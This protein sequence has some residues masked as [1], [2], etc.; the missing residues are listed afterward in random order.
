[1]HSLFERWVQETPEATAVVFE[2]ESLSYAA[3]E[4]RANSIASALVERGVKA[5]D[6]VGLYVER[7]ADMLAALLGILK[8]GAA[9]VPMDPLFPADRLAYML[10]DAQVKLVLTQ[11]ALLAE[12]PAGR[13]DGKAR[14][15]RSARAWARTWR[16]N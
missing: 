12:A 16:Q 10:E 7:S 1:M 11:R 15:R 9:Y 6:L 13:A 2:G 3:L 4:E 8:S 5:G 14:S